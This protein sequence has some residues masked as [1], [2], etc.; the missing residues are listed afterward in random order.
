[1]S[2]LLVKGV[3]RWW[4]RDHRPE[5]RPKNRHD[6][7][8]KRHF[9]ATRPHP[10]KIVFQALLMDADPEERLIANNMATPKTAGALLAKVFTSRE[11]SD[12]TNAISASCGDILRSRAIR[13]LEEMLVRHEKQ[14]ANGAGENEREI[15]DKTALDV[16]RLLMGYHR[17]TQK[18][19]VKHMAASGGVVGELGSM[20]DKD[21]LRLLASTGMQGE[22]VVS[23][24]I[25]CNSDRLQDGIDSPGSDEADPVTVEEV[26]DTV[27][28]G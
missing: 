2:L 5:W 3:D 17:D 28:N 10:S 4:D 19:M 16:V 12:E 11:F 7:K 22:E 6:V 21:L 15:S 24:A 9:K 18:Q 14:L 25:D 13:T 27:V 1:M 8:L 26:E 23:G 20:S